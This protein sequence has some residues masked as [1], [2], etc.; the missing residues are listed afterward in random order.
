MNRL[1]GLWRVSSPGMRRAAAMIVDVLIVLESLVV[2]LLFRFDGAVPEEFWNSFWPFAALSAV[3]FVTF[4]FESKVYRNVLK[5]TGVYQGVRVASA[6]LLAVGVLVIANLGVDLVWSRPVP[7]SVILV[8]G[9]LAFV[10][11]VAVRLYPRV[12]YERSLREIE[13]S[14]RALI[15]GAGEAGV[16]L[17]RQLSRTPEADLKPVGFAAADPRA[18]ARLR[19][20]QIEGIPVL[21]GVEDIER[22]VEEQ[23]ADQILIAL[24]DATSEEIDLIWRECVKTK[25]EVKVVPKLSEFLGQGTIRL[26]QVQIQDLLGRQPVEIDIDAL[27]EFINGKRVLI[28]GA[29]GSIGSE[30]SRQISRLGPACLVLLDRDESALYYLN[31]E[32]SREGFT[33]AELAVGDVTNLEKTRAL[34]ARLRPH[35]VF[36]AAAYK[37]VPLMELHASEAVS[38]N[39]GGTLVV[40]RVAGE[41]GVEKFINVSTDKAVHPVNVMGAT[42]RF[43]EMLVRSA[44]EEYPETLYASVRFG[45]VLGSRGS[46]VPTFRRQ[47]EAGGPVTV[48]H[49]EMTRYFMITSEAVSL[50]LQA[51]AM[52]DS[53][54]IYVLEMGRPVKIVDLA[55]KM[56][57]VMG[58]RGVKIKYVGLRPGEKLHE[59]LSEESEDRAATDHPMV[60]RLVPK[61]P[62]PSDLLGV[63][64]EMS[65]FALSGDDEKTLELLR[66]AVPNYRVVESGTARN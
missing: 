51:G 3:V 21:G 54:G 13:Q 48:T 18:I 40:A 55:T 38:N 22:L 14:G 10:Q 49:P 57:E 36:H 35:L 39:V 64:E 53:Y 20:E 8:G 41:F 19:G 2:A 26:R 17:A 59:T 15:V 45:N 34:F 46:V 56:I 60:Y 31:E 16:T 33:G 66:R 12:F 11:L 29:G 6:T 32:L 47:I 9:V 4:L 7:L 58:A 28:T 42:K 63:A 23:G 25:A 44:A 30:L 37:H 50:I 52:A 27:A 1:R 65:V 43:S 62:P 24:P 5:Y 61:K